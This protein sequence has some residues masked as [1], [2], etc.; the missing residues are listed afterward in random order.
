M[1]ISPPQ[2][3]PPEDDKWIEENN[4]RRFTDAD[5]IAETVSSEDTVEDGDPLGKTLTT[6]VSRM[7][8]PS[9]THRVTSAGTT[10]TTDPHYE[11]DWESETDPANPRNW[12]LPY[13]AM[14]IAFL[15]WNTL[16]V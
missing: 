9:L 16:V 5:S 12:S 6:R 2:N 8:E 13:K 7:S 11:V 1:S 14:M 10:G 3:P 15:S 4:G